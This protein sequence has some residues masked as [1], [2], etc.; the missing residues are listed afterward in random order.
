MRHNDFHHRVAL[1]AA[2]TYIGIAPQINC[3]RGRKY[4]NVKSANI[5]K[6]TEINEKTKENPRKG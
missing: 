4:L 3:K 1:T 2:F 6:R 5:R